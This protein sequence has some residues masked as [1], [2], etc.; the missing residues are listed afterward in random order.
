MCSCLLR[1]CCTC[2]L[3]PGPQPGGP[4][5]QQ[6]GELCCHHRHKPAGHRRGRK[7][8]P[9]LDKCC[10]PCRLEVVKMVQSLKCCFH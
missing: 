4:D 10:L 2:Q 7:E 9:G 5:L 6:G 3:A 1:E 8:S